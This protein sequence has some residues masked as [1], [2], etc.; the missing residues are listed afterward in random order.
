M[1]ERH[2]HKVLNIDYDE[3]LK[4]RAREYSRETLEQYYVDYQ[5]LRYENEDLRHYK[6]YTNSFSLL[7]IV[8]AYAASCFA[9]CKN[10]DSIISLL[11][12]SLLCTVFSLV[13][14]HTLKG[15]LWDNYTNHDKPVPLSTVFITIAIITVTAI[16]LR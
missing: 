14:S 2:I 10:T 7:S 1:D 8:T 5:K 4:E 16:I 13:A 9:L 6:A 3:T 11:L 15:F 12:L